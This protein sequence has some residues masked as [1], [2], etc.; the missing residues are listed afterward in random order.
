M[1]DPSGGKEDLG[2]VKGGTKN[3]LPR[4]VHFMVHIYIATE[5]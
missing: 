3:Q 2:Q 5:Y 4:D 1:G